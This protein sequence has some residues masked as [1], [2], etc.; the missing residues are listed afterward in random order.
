MA[1]ISCLLQHILSIT[2]YT[3]RQAPLRG[4]KLL[5]TEVQRKQLMPEILCHA[6][7]RG[8]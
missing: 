4:S 7:Q 8:I 1:V 2:V 6:D 3:Q 5:Q